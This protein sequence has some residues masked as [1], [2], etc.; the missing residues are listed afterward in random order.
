MK[1]TKIFFIS[2]LAC[3]LA[4]CELNINPDLENADRVL[5][6]NG[7]ITN[8][9]GNQTI[10]LTKT[11]PY[12]EKSL[13]PT[14]A[15]ATVTVSDDKGGVFNFSED[16]TKKGN[17]VW[18]PTANELFGTIGNSY[19]LSIQ[20]EGEIFESFAK[21]GRV[22]GIDSIT[23]KKNDP[24]KLNP[25]FYIAQQWATD[26]PGKGD[27]YWVRAVKNGQRLNK[28]AEINIAADAGF[29]PESTIDGI[30]FLPN[31]RE[32]ISPFDK[33]ANGTALS[34][35]LPGDSVYVEIHSITLAA[36]NH[37]QQVSIQTNRPG[38]FAE[39]FATPLSNVSSNIRN[40]NPSGKKVVGFFNV[41]AVSGL[42]KRFPKK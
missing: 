2:I 39:L 5:V 36:F 28:P 32:G 13:P 11:Q 7:W 23:L 33:D 30:T 34:P 8:R 10:V 35:Y 19:K 18:K 38:G 9:P 15:G 37:L 41:A 21:M 16:P 14:V 4:A 12:F 27:F 31:V 25:D 20:S 6:V 40:V 26:I 22:P 24:D 3:L 1:F 17:Y 42:G 29:A